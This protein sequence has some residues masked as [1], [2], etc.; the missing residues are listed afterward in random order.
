M[1]R[2]GGH[3]ESRQHTKPGFL[4]A[5]NAQKDAH[6]SYKYRKGDLWSRGCKP[7]PSAP[8][9]ATL[10][11]PAGRLSEGELWPPVQRLCVNSQH[12]WDH[13]TVNDYRTVTDHKNVS[14]VEEGKPARKL[15]MEMET[16]HLAERTF[17]Q[18]ASKY[19]KY[20]HI[21]ILSVHDSKWLKLTC[22]GLEE[23]QIFYISVLKF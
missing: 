2:C 5:S 8:P 16:M 20:L 17:F 3:I 15:S 23:W 11:P 14:V 19:I 4:S 10:P 9:S 7:L 6:V 1:L 12:G 18:M 22:W 21:Y 13:W